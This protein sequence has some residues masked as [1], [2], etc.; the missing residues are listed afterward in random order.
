MRKFRFT[1]DSLTSVN[2]HRCLNAPAQHAEFVSWLPST[3]CNTS[4]TA[5]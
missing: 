5:G 4:L 1:Q 2:Q 3:K